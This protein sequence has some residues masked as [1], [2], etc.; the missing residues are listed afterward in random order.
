MK[1]SYDDDDDDDDDNC[2]CSSQKLSSACLQT[3]KITVYIKQFS[4]CFMWV[5]N[6]I[7]YFE[8]RT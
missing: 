2:C 4:S 3:L 8:A 7:P 6:V 5:W 1:K